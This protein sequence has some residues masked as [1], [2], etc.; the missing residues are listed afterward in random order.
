MFHLISLG[1][2]SLWRGHH[3]HLCW[4][5]RRR[6]GLCPAS[7]PI[8]EG[9]AWYDR[10]SLICQWCAIRSGSVFDPAVPNV[11]R[12][13]LAD[14]PLLG[15][16]EGDGV[17]HDLPVRLPCSVR[18]LPLAEGKWRTQAQTWQGHEGGSVVR[19]GWSSGADCAVFQLFFFS[20]SRRAMVAGRIAVTFLA[21][22]S[23]V[24]RTLRSA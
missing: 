23:V 5:P 6:C 14:R 12:H 20:S 7:T 4:N 21:S 24:R 18:R 19:C 16:E 22:P 13:G 9:R 8:G 15:S 1:R 3:M 2:P 17:L 11:L 10:S